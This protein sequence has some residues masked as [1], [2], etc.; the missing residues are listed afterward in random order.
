MESRRGASVS[1]AR[2]SVAAENEGGQKFLPNPF[3]FARP[4]VQCGARSAEINRDFAQKRFALHS[5]I[6]KI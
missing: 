6:V 2:N 4:S 1:L 3:L 5:V